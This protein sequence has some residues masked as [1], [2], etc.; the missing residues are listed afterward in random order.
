MNTT[1]STFQL[2]GPS[3][4]R[5]SHLYGTNLKEQNLIEKIARGFFAY[6]GQENPW[7]AGSLV[8]V[9]SL[10]FLFSL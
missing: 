9:L 6:L 4:N 1:Y 8:L 5:G 7:Q 10:F 3:V 2:I